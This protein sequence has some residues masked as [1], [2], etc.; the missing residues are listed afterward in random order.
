MSD[1][2]SQLSWWK[3]RFWSHVQWPW[4]QFDRRKSHATCHLA[5]RLKRPFHGN[6]SNKC[7]F[8]A[9]K[10]GNAIDIPPNSSRLFKI[11]KTSFEVV[12][13]STTVELLA[14][15]HDVHGRRKKRFDAAGNSRRGR[16]NFCH[17]GR[18]LNWKCK[19]IR[20]QKSKYLWK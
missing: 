15:H 10:Q 7:T 13:H 12:R 20:K 8:F 5:R 6:L 16:V 19:N 11:C 3:A 14:R 1:I 17:N 18:N 9:E 2:R 4:C